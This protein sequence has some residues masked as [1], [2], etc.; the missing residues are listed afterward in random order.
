KWYEQSKRNG[1]DYYEEVGDKLDYKYEKTRFFPRIWDANQN[2]PAFY[3]S[4]LGL[5]EGESP[6]TADN[7]SFF[8]RYQLNWMWWR[9]FMWNYVGRQNDV[10][11]QGGPK[12]GN[13]ISG[14]S[15]L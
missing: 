15:F 2:H 12:D 7:F 3:R 9:Y 11:G 14:I 4:Y 13:W 5:S 8:F 1:K 6:T 10:E